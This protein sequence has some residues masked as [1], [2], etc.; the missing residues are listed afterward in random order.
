LPITCSFFSEG[1]IFEFPGKTLLQ[2]TAHRFLNPSYNHVTQ[3]DRI[4]L[5]LQVF[6]CRVP[7][8]VIELNGLSYMFR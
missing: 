2:T 4:L 6:H 5:I 8:I 3:P 1:G 7:F